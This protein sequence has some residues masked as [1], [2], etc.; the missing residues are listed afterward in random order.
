MLRKWNT[1][2]IHELGPQNLFYGLLTGN[3]KRHKFIGYVGALFQNGFSVNAPFFMLLCNTPTAYRFVID[4]PMDRTMHFNVNSFCPHVQFWHYRSLFCYLSY[5][6][7]DLNLKSLININPQKKES[8]HSLVA[9]VKGH[10]ILT[11]NG[12]ISLATSSQ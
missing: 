9:S 2:V 5:V 8:V 12:N 10:D 11:K 1:V 6:Y 4:S 3:R 7:R